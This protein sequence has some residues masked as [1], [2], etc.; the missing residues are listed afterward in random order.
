MTERIRLTVSITPETHEVFSRIAAAHSTSL[1]RA[2]GDWL[3]DTHEG[4]AFVAGKVEEA[5]RSPKTAM[6]S[7]QALGLAL[8][9]EATEQLDQI[10]RGAA[11]STAP[12]RSAQPGGQGQWRA[13]P[14]S[15]N[16]GGKSPSAPS[17]SHKSKARK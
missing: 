1:G 3:S 10:R 13:V 17:S 9:D 15:G 6:R 2:I 4:A 12:A 16:T 14:P 11:S 5:R 8:H 7:F